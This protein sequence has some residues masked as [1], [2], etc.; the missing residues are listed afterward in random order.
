[1]Q[2]DAVTATPAALAELARL[3]ARHGPLML[4]QSAGCC[5]G[6]S[7]LCLPRGELFVGPGD[8]LLGDVDGTPF[9]VEE[10]L[11]RRWR[12]PAFLVDLADGA[13]DAFSL[14]AADGVHFV[15]NTAPCEPRSG[16]APMRSAP[17]KKTMAST[18]A[19]EADVS[20][21]AQRIREATALLGAGNEAG[22]LQALHAA[23]E[24]AGD[25]PV[26]GREVHDLATL[27]HD[28]SHGFHKIEWQRLMFDTEP[29]STAV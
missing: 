29:H 27:A 17:G 12:A 21:P 2:A 22:A 1:V 28:T 25:D 7:P 3:R 4:V 19:K 15:S 10:E 8:L 13:G 23:L 6:S 16:R 18:Q 14:E 20:D 24:A 9:F 11:Y 5:D 26:V